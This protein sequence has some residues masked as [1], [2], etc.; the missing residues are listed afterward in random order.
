[1][2]G[3]I[4]SPRESRRFLDAVQRL[5]VLRAGELRRLNLAVPAETLMHCGPGLF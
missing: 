1:L 3:E 2:T 4:L 5:S